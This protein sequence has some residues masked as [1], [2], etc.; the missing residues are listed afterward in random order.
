MR[1]LRLLQASRSI[2]LLCSWAGPLIGSLVIQMLTGGL[3]IQILVLDHSEMLLEHHEQVRRQSEAIGLER[4][5]IRV[6]AEWH[7]TA[8]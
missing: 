8:S 3:V 1:L 2:K 5:I 4:Q 6:A 7:L